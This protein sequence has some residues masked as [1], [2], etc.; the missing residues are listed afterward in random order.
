MVPNASIERD[1]CISFWGEYKCL[2]F[3]A[4]DVTIEWGEGAK[5]AQERAQ[6]SLVAILLERAQERI[7]ERTLEKAPDRVKVREH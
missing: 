2:R 3:L 6:V 1:H 7:L 5:W 4:P